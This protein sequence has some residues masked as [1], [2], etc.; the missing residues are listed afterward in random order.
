MRNK[1]I[2][3]KTI[4]G[5]EDFLDRFMEKPQ[6]ILARA[7]H[8]PNGLKYP[9][10]RH[11]AIQFLYAT[12]GVMK[13]QTTQGVWVVPNNRAVWI[14]SNMPHQIEATGPLVMRNLYFK[15]GHF[16]QLPRTCRTVS[17]TPLLREL[18]QYATEMPSDYHDNSPETRLLDVIVDQIET[19]ETA[20]LSLPTP[21]DPRLLIITNF[22]EKNPCNNRTLESWGTTAGATQRTLARLFLKETGMTFSQWRR[23]ARLIEALRMLAQGVPV[24]ETAFNTGY[25][26]VSAFIYMFRKA[27]G[28]T[29]G[30]FF[31]P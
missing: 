11:T 19:L 26:S 10:H 13:A 9:L 3:K 8:Y 25:E 21:Q 22:L 18:I 12:Q 23:Q 6:K 2:E 1:N 7:F 5:A 24:N 31:D 4:F 30:R 20:A 15:P 16:L 29:P 14:P 17:V 27:L 28:C